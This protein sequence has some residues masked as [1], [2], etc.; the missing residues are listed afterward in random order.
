MGLTSKIIPYDGSCGAAC[1]TAE[2]KYRNIL[3]ELT[4]VLVSIGIEEFEHH[5]IVTDTTY[6]KVLIGMDFLRKSSGMYDSKNG[7]PKFAGKGTA[8]S[9]LEILERSAKRRLQLSS[10]LPDNPAVHKVPIYRQANTY[11]RGKFIQAAEM[12]QIDIL[13]K[14]ITNDHH[15]DHAPPKPPDVKS[16]TELVSETNLGEVYHDTS[17]LETSQIWSTAPTSD[18]D[19]L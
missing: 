15:D 10:M 16:F 8:P 5:F 14:K 2:N 9:V 19:F 1:T 18:L 4:D 11:K 13:K 17:G 6:C 7:T 12:E 3:G